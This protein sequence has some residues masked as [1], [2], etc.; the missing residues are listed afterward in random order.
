MSQRR[1]RGRR[2]GEGGATERD[3]ALALASKY[4]GTNLYRHIPTFRIHTQMRGW[5]KE[6]IFP[7][8]VLD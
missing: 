7:F 8:Q 4:M 2:G 6:C 3:I 1:L 5:E